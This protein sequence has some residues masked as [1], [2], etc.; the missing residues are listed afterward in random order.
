LQIGRFFVVVCGMTEAEAR[1]LADDLL[2]HGW[3]NAEVIQSRD[4][5]VWFVLATNKHGQRCIF[6]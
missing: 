1:E 5:S 3:P 2:A 6:P 4:G